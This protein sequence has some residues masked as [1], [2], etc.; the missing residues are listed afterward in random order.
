MSYSGGPWSSSN[1]TISARFVGNAGSLLQFAE[2]ADDGIEHIT[3]HSTQVELPE[4]LVANNTEIE[5]MTHDNSV[6]RLVSAATI[7]DPG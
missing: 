6:S 7:Q 1:Q 5:I 2:V 3:D 4:N